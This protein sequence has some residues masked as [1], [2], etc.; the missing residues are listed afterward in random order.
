MMDN[1][2]NL[3]THVKIHITEALMSCADKKDLMYLSISDLMHDVTSAVVDDLVSFSEKDPASGHNPH[4]ILESYTSFMAILHYRIA[5]SIE[6]KSHL[7]N[8]FLAAHLSKRGKLLSGAEIHSRCKIGK[9]FVLDH[10]IGTVIGETAILGDD[11]YVLGGVT[12]GAKGICKNPASPR[13]PI[14]GHRVQIGAGTSIL[15]R[16]TIG[17]DVFIGSNCII[18]KDIPNNSNVSVK[19]NLKITQ[20]IDTA[21]KLHA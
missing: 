5:H 2:E 15:G 14:I 9:R 11:C 20:K 16:V 1:F 13:H 8:T 17:D 6:Q 4:L 21:G 3:Y 12:L 18:S 19:S 10:G 7:K